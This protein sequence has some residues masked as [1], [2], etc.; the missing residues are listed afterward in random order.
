MRIAK[1]NFVHDVCY[2]SRPHTPELQSLDVNLLWLRII[3]TS[4]FQSLTLNIVREINF[5]S[6]VLMLVLLPSNPDSPKRMHNGT[7]HV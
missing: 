3:F 6:P 1:Q 5:D 2:E 4:S 7:K